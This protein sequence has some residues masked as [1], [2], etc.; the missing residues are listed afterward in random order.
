MPDDDMLEPAATT[1]A[2]AN[3]GAADNTT[4]FTMD[5]ALKAFPAIPRKPDDRAGWCCLLDRL[6]LRRLVW[7]ARLL[8]PLYNCVCSWHDTLVRRADASQQQ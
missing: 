8:S 1:A 2:T 5:M 7:P 3:P 6:S 4:V